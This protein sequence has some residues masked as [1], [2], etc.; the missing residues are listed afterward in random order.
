VSRPSARCARAR[1]WS[2]GQSLRS[3]LNRLAIQPRRKAQKLSF[4]CLARRG[5]PAMNR[6]CF[7]SVTVNDVSGCRIRPSHETA[8]S[9]PHCGRGPAIQSDYPAGCE[10]AARQF[11]RPVIWIRARRRRGGWRVGPHT[12]KAGGHKVF[13]GS[14]ERLPR[15]PPISGAS[16]LHGLGQPA[17]SVLLA[18]S[19][20]SRSAS[21][22]QCG[23]LS[24]AGKPATQSPNG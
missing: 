1:S 20:E 21:S 12:G 11:A 18:S 19:F 17:I 3:T 13:R 24:S 22:S 8:D 16:S 6:A 14:T 4:S 15:L 7:S 23:E 5:P 10:S 2:G 9:R